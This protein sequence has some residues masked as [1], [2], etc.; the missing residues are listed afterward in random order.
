MSLAKVNFCDL[1]ATDLNDAECIGHKRRTKIDI[2]FEKTIEHVD[3]EIKKCAECN[4]TVKAPF[5]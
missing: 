5:P 1:C 4:A 3:A 2:V